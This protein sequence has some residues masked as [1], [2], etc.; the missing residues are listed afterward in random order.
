MAQSTLNVRKRV[1]MGKSG[2]RAIR[3]EGNV[4]A[5]LYGKGEEPLALV[6]NPGDLK[7]ALLTEAGENTLLEIVVENESEKIKKL[8]LLREIQ[9]DYI[10]SKPIHF[11]FQTLDVKKKIAVNVPVVITG[12]SKGV[13][14]GGIL[15]EILRE[16]SVECLPTDIPN[17]YEVDVTELEIGDSIH[18]NTLEI[19][20]GVQILNDDDETIV[21]VLAPRLEVT[22]T[23]EEE[24]EELEGEEG[25]EA[26]E[27]EEAEE[28]QEESSEE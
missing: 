3:K 1:R 26:V 11:D 24:E 18:V 25:E 4:P 8:S 9:Y 7:Q 14:E 13:K 10:T 23:E 27:G 28:T 20:E 5:I 15:E 12:R 6:I 2:A 17:S 21:T 16:I 19:T 22:T